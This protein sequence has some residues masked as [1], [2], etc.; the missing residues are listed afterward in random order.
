MIFN[1]FLASPPNT[2]TVVATTDDTLTVA[3]KNGTITTNRPDATAYHP[4]DLVRLSN[5]QP[6]G[7]L[8]KPSQIVRV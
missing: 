7:R 4:G 6:T 1:R 8:G 3:T 5:G 2:G